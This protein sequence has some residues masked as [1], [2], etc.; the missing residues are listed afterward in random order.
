MMKNLVLLV[1]LAVC[2]CPYYTFGSEV[3]QKS[4]NSSKDVIVQKLKTIIIPKLDFEDVTISTGC[5]YLREMSKKLDSA[6]TGVNIFLKL[7]PAEKEQ[8][9][10]INLIL[11]NKTLGECLFF[12]CA[13][14]RLELR[15]DT[16]AV[17]IS[18]P[19]SASYDITQSEASILA[20]GTSGET[21]TQFN[22]LTNNKL[23]N[24]IFPSVDF[25]EADI[26][27]VIRYLNRSSKRYDRD[28]A[29]ISIVAG[30]TK[31]T[32]AVLP[33]LTMI[34]TKIPMNELLRYICENGCLKYTICKGTIIFTV[35][36]EQRAKGYRK[37]AEQGNAKAQYNLGV[38]YS[39]GAGVAK[40]AAE[41][42]KWYRRAAEQG[43]APAQ[44]KLGENYNKGSGVDKDTAKAIEWLRKG[45]EQ[46]D[47]KAQFSLGCYYNDEGATK[48]NVQAV[49]WFRKSAEQGNADAQGSLGL[50]YY[51][52]SGV[53]KNEEEAVK[54]LRKSAEQGVAET[55]TILGIC[56]E[57]GTG[58]AKDYTEAA[59]WYR[60]AAEQGYA[61][62][63]YKLGVY[64][65]N[66]VGVAKDKYE[67]AKWLRKAA[68][69]GDAKA[70]EAL[71]KL[72]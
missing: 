30:F 4:N 25:N 26:F 17:V 22:M 18:S 19:E 9:P 39:D 63:Q 41:A 29:G 59:K 12:I 49:K 52:G 53:A 37:A 35:D 31:E 62:A 70:K 24:I 7:A 71:E 43:Y 20:L 54:W 5:A 69:Q 27:S 57:E 23:E 45:A 40:D 33:K 58:V 72:K 64:Y 44:H 66:G 34:F 28:M 38:C 10:V 48:D 47:A 67:A 46:G 55:Q 42:V 3:S 32:A 1:V 16:N 14:A 2:L 61:D 6:G 15:I 56:Y 13:A 60:K 36:W 11:N 50:C 51:S 21:L 65:G 68:A 8:E